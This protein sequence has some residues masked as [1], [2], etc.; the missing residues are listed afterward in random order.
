MQLLLTYLLV[1]IPSYVIPK[2]IRD[3]KNAKHFYKIKRDIILNLKRIKCR[4]FYF[5]G[6]FGLGS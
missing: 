1:A 6:N 4:T 2:K 3:R 5:Y